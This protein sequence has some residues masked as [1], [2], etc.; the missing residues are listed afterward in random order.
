VPFKGDGQA[1]PAIMSG[2]VATGMLPL[3]ASP[4]HIRAG[5]LRALAVTSA[6]RVKAL[7]QVPTIA[8][9]GYPGFE[10]LTWHS[11][12]VRA[13]TPPDIVRKLNG[14]IVRILKSEEFRSKVPDPSAVIVANSP[15]EFA[16]FL[17]SE[18]ARWKKVIE[19]GG[20]RLE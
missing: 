6:S 13:G 1:I 9:S 14:E 7:P 4:Q 16:R 11:V 12:A 8:E 2:E 20:F 3:G 19:T 5:R 17:Q 15:E 10:A 18:N